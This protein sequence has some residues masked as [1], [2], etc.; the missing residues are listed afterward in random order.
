M[1]LRKN[2]MQLDMVINRPQH[3]LF[4]PAAEQVA[5]SSLRI[6]LSS[7]NLNTGYFSNIS[8]A[9]R[10]SHDKN[11]EVLYMWMQQQQK[12]KLEIG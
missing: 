1:Y 10:N 3:D 4:S 7:E 12:T 8:D 6:T 9:L 11:I 2:V 5:W